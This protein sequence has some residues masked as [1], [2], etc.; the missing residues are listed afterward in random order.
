MKPL[1]LADLKAIVERC[2]RM[3][4][5]DDVLVVAV[6]LPPGEPATVK[7]LRR[8]ALRLVAERVLDDLNQPK[9]KQ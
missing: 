9:E 3:G 1:T 6:T 4:L 2:S 8:R 5:T 7:N